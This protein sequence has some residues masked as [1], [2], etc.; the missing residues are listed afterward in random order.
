MKKT[1]HIVGLVLLTA[2]VGVSVFGVFTPPKAEAVVSMGACLAARLAE[3]G[4]AAGKVAL[5]ALAF[6]GVAAP[7][8]AEVDAEA[9]AGTSLVQCF[10][11]GFAV[12][13]GRTLLHTF[14][15]SIVNW[16]NRGF[17]G[18]P[19]FV[20]DLG[21][22]F[23]DVADQT[24]GQAIEQVAPLLCEPFRFD[25][26]LALGLQASLN[27]EQTIRCRLSDVVGNLEGSYQGFVG[28]DFRQ[29]GWSRFINVTG[30]PQNN[31]YGAYLATQNY[32][33]ARIVTASGREQKLLDFGKG[34]KSW[35]PCKVKGDPYSAVDK[36]GAPIMKDGQPLVRT[37]PCKEY[38][39]IRTPGSVIVDQANES[40]KTT[41]DELEVAQDI[42]AVVGALINQLLV[43][44][45]TGI[46]GLLGASRS[47]ATD[48][49]RSSADSLATDPNKILNQVDVKPPEGI[50]C[51][52]RYYPAVE[53]TYTGLRPIDAQNQVYTAKTD[54]KGRIVRS[55]GYILTVPAK[56]RDAQGKEKPLLKTTATWDDYFEQ[57]KDGCA[58]KVQTLL[59]KEQGKVESQ[60][61]GGAKVSLSGGVG[62]QP[63][64]GNLSTGKFATQSSDQSQWIVGKTVRDIPE[65]YAYTAV[66]G[67]KSGGTEFYGTFAFTQAGKSSEWWR[68]DLETERNSKK[69][70]WTVNEIREIT[71]YRPAGG[72]ESSS[73]IN[74]LKDGGFA[75]SIL[76]EIERPVWTSPVFTR[77][78]SAFVVPNLPPRIKGRYVKITQ[79]GGG[80]MP[81]AI[82]EV[83]IIGTQVRLDTNT[84]PPE[85]Q[86]S[87]SVD[88][89]TQTLSAPYTGDSFT[90]KGISLLPSKAAEGISLRLT[91]FEKCPDN[92]QTPECPTGAYKKTPTPFPSFFNAVV[93]SVTQEGALTPAPNFITATRTLNTA[94][95]KLTAVAY[96]ADDR[97]ASSV[98]FARG[99]SLTTKPIYVTLYGVPTTRI[100]FKLVL[101][102]LQQDKVIGSATVILTVP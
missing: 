71:V 54:D 83:E 26:R 49:G 21:G 50:D 73:Y 80:E 14:T 85:L 62:S 78:G 19:S 95:G 55:Q 13:I 86:F 30:V 35:R 100:P 46:G 31:P 48:G 17:E 1:A 81:L 61:G 23:T 37:G 75:V 11:R 64:E 93:P 24:F 7:L 38:G 12:I 2:F 67:N 33:G 45:M 82:A 56:Y 16:I 72:W 59:D 10:L 44:T 90:A 70:E 74:T 66:D 36:K 92:T 20:T 40:L 4:T 41:L 98:V 39:E 63:Q 101:D 29:G 3:G 32:I 8:N 87:L 79:A 77:V 27:T 15:Q 88:P 97:N 43:K 99:L 42:D 52:Q 68:V 65:P 57:I 96:N 94:D 76:D 5:G 34:F 69:Q 25:L 9:G 89:E 53:A 51:K 60:I 22:F 84:P 6:V 28:G 91:F 18:E 58:N 47:H 102:V